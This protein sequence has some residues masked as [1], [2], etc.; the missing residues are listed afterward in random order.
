MD[1]PIAN[2]QL[3]D[4][5]AASIGQSITKRY[6]AK[7]GFVIAM[8]GPVE[9]LP[10]GDVFQAFTLQSNAGGLSGVLGLTSLILRHMAEWESR[11]RI[12]APGTH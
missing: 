11:A 1:E 5:L 8:T 7:I 12:V 6:G 9:E 2:Q 4:D 10:D 3:I